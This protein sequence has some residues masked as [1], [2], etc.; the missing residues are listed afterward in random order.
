MTSVF[1]DRSTSWV[2]IVNGVEKYVREAM[3][4]QEGEEASGKPA[5]KA[6]SIL[7]P[8]STSNP[9]FNPM[10][11]RRWIDIEVQKSKDQSCYQMSKFITNLLR[12]GEDGREKMPEFLMKKILRHAK[13]NCQRIQDI[14]QTK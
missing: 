1:E 4:I 9:N 13:K 12:H 11:D 7:K 5:A 8:A 10:K 3:P 6:K 2:K 14:G